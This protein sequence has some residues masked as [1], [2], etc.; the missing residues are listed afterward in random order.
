M[1]KLIKFLKENEEQYEKEQIFYENVLVEIKE[2]IN[3]E[4]TRSKI[5]Y[6]KLLI[7]LASLIILVLPLTLYLILKTGTVKERYLNP[8]QISFNEAETMYEENVDLVEIA[9]IGDSEAKEELYEA[10]L[11]TLYQNKRQNNVINNAGNVAAY[12]PANN[13]L[14]QEK[15]KIYTDY[16]LNSA[17]YF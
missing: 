14:L 2:K 17:G 4:K 7:S 6:N 15:A 3:N 8:V 5:N 10:V 13:E 9:R 16:L 11:E 12:I 1:K